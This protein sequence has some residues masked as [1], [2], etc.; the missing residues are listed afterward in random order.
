[1]YGK[2][3]IGILIIIGLSF[4]ACQDAS[5]REPINYTL[6]VDLQ[7]RKDTNTIDTS[8]RPY[9]SLPFQWMDDWSKDSLEFWANTHTKRSKQILQTEKGFASLYS[10]LQI[11]GFPKEINNTYY[12]LAEFNGQRGIY[13]GSDL[14]TLSTYQPFLLDTTLNL[15][16]YQIYDFEPL[17]STVQGLALLL[18]QTQ[19]HEYKTA[20]Y[21]FPEDSVLLWANL[22]VSTDWQVKHSNIWVHSPS[23]DLIYQ[24]QPDQS[25]TNTYA[26]DSFRQAPLQLLGI[27][28]SSQQLVVQVSEGI[29]TTSYYQL[30]TQ[31]P[32]KKIFTFRKGQ[33]K[34]LGYQDEK[35][36]FQADFKNGRPQIFSYRAT[37]EKEIL[38]TITDT[39]STW[40]SYAKLQD[41]TILGLNHKEKYAALRAYSLQ[42][43]LLYD[44]ELP[45]ALM[46]I[47]FKYYPEGKHTLV[48]QLSPEDGLRWL[49]IDRTLPVQVESVYRS[50]VSSAQI[51]IQS[52]WTRIP[53][54]DGTYIPLVI[55][56]RPGILPL[57]K[58]PSIIIPVSSDFET[59]RRQLIDLS[60]VNRGL[61]SDMTVIFIFPRGNQ[62]LGQQWFLNGSGPRLQLAY[63]DLQ[64]CLS[65]LNEQQI[66]A[67]NQR[68][69]WGIQEGALS[70]AALYMQ[71]PELAS[72]VILQDGIYDLRKLKTQQNYTAWSWLNTPDS[73][74]ARLSIKYS[75]QFYPIRSALYPNCLVQTSN[76][77][78]FANHSQSFKWVAR[79]QSLPGSPSVWLHSETIHP[80]GQASGSPQWEQ[81]VWNFMHK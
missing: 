62:K 26:L 36:Y 69:V 11:I 48:R 6:P 45:P 18:Y 66:G 52:N 12:A 76:Q 61:Q 30:S 29:A 60:V 38:H 40:L 10:N 65:Y 56:N 9:L 63:D 23:D 24:V 1:M 72:S 51:P 42:G 7:L 59:F 80:V 44:H 5:V 16:G 53:S 79:L 81:M 58:R 25:Y 70:A 4:W 50:L 27:I 20:F 49:N 33:N 14:S 73:L 13:Q 68:T 37:P 47:D 15:P 64:A 32:P 8:Y 28:D 54:Y 67:A 46:S 74:S 31:R 41:S 77:S 17:D 43:Q 34:W 75:P 78:I 35:H 22:N 21:N 57:K 55:Y 3:K 19:K 39:D 71:R 2:Q